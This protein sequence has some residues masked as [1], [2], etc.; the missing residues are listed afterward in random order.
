MTSQLTQEALR[1]LASNLNPR[2]NGFY[3]EGTP[4]LVATAAVGRVLGI[5][6]RPPS[7]WENLEQIKEP[8]EAIIRASRIQMRQVLLEDNW[9]KK[10]CSP[11]IAYKEEDRQP[12]ALLPSSRGYE[13]Y[14]PVNQTLIPVNKKIADTLSYQAHMLYRS[15]PDKVIKVWDLIKFALTGR[16]KDIN[17]I[18]M[19]GIAVT[20]LGM[21][22]PQATAIIID[23]AIP[24]S[25]RNL[26]LQIS[27]VLLI[28]AL[29]TALFNLSQGLAILRMETTTDAH[30][31]AA[32]WDRLLNLSASFFRLYPSG[33]LQ[34][35]VSSINT[36]HR[37]ISGRTL[38]NFI[39]SLFALFY[40]VQLFYYNRNLALLPAFIAFF[41]FTITTIAGFLLIA[42][43]EALLELQGH[44]FGQIVQ[45]INGISKLH[46]AGAQERAFAY[47]SKNYSRQIKLEISTQKIEDTVVLF[48]TIMPT[49]TNSLLFLAT[50]SLLNQTEN[51]DN[52]TILSLGTF[53]AFNAA[54]A[55]FINGTTKLSNT[56]TEILHVIPQWKRVKPI[57]QTLPEVDINKAEPGRLTGKILVKNITFRYHNDG[58]VIL[59]NIN[60]SAE[61]G[62]FIAI[63]GTSGS[64]KSTLFRLLLGFEKTELGS[65]YYDGQDLSGLNINAVRRQLGVVLQNTQLQSSSIF[66]IIRGGANITL[67]EA[68]EAAQ[69]A[70]LA[71]DITLMPMG[72]HTY[73]SEGGGNLSGGQRQRLLIA[74]ALALK[75][76]ILLFD[77]ATSALDNQTQAIV[78][79]SLDKLQVTR[80]VIAHRLSTI[81]NAKRIYV[82]QSGRIIQQGSFEELAKVQGLFAQLI[83]RQNL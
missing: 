83:A 57:L 36:I 18:I 5:S 6:I 22:I 26:L 61:P 16:G 69:M 53:L 59:E 38:I 75:P 9:W 49:F 35:R 41:T 64:G 42:K 32:V 1:E 71:E 23:N 50:V 44:I 45:F 34:S 14:N 58:A 62:D 24:D 28:A 63:V 74:R 70:G 67:D 19:T 65:I 17:I 80:I 68:W 52:S 7:H 60:I 54:F 48:N 11:L 33:D 82:L 77:E 55:N 51:T 46:I 15:L 2:N 29:G 13:I 3:I 40:L 39:T 81:R 10:D 21:L 27:L 4:L 31:Q 66:E 12:V 56:I 25:N 30:T 37:Q 8:L 72:M 76:K 43:V 73:I 78:S 20:L 47:W 79:Q